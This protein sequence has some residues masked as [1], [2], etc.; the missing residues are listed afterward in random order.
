MN[1][2]KVLALLLCLS[3]CGPVTV[4]YTLACVAQCASTGAQSNVALVAC[5]A[6]GQDPTSIAAANVAACVTS[7]KN[8]GCPD[9]TCACQATRTTTLCTP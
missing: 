8:A 2:T 5:D 6:D 4:T 1:P 7:A 3:G 9:P